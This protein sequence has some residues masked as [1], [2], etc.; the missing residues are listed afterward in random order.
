MA[1]IDKYLKSWKK[2]LLS[3]R[4]RRKQ[5]VEERVA[6]RRRRRSWYHPGLAHQQRLLP[7]L[8]YLPPPYCP[9][10][11][12]QPF[13]SYHKWAAGPWRNSIF[14]FNSFSLNSSLGF[15][16]GEEKSLEQV[17][18]LNRRLSTNT[19]WKYK[20]SC[21]GSETSLGFLLYCDRRSG[22]LPDTINLGELG[23]LNTLP[24]VKVKCRWGCIGSLL[25]SRDTAPFP[26]EQA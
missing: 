16:Q 5:I 18:V 14:F 13:L 25:C 15:D 10:L 9:S 17:E 11:L 26:S 4:K 24:R 22:S 3:F 6:R 21:L 1:E 2:V 19:L 23:F 20:E 8:V 7:T 12:G